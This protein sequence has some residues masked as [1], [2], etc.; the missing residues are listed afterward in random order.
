MTNNDERAAQA[1]FISN[2][3][4]GIV[5]QACEQGVDLHHVAATVLAVGAKGLHIAMGP[6][7]AAA[8]IRSVA[9]HVEADRGPGQFDA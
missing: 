2:V 9:M 8:W 1:Q 3:V 4:V 6:D 5:R 7:D